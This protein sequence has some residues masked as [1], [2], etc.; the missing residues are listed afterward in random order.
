MTPHPPPE[1]SPPSGTPE[2][3][4]NPTPRPTAGTPDRRALVQA[5]QD[6]VRGEKEKGFQRHRPS[7]PPAPRRGLLA[8]LLLT[9]AALAWVLAA[10]PEW[11]FPRPAPE[12]PALSEASLRVRMF[13]EID[14]IERY[15]AQA[16]HRP[17][18]LIEAGA[19]TVG[20]IYSTTENGYTLTG[21]N[22]GFTLTYRSGEPPRTF[23]GD[24]YRL[25]R[26]R[27]S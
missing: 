13:V 5:F 20:L 2:R 12:P 6:V 19:D 15:T 8:F 27:G 25:V 1:S 14:R 11:L 26:Q 23:L 22:Q 9:T 17:A 7:A 10:Q 24:S 4:S 21:V 3:R 16:G 18:S